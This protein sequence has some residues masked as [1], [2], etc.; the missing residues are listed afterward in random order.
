MD[1]AK[2]VEPL[3]QFRTV[4]RENKTM[5]DSCTAPRSIEYY[6]LKG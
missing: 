6:S 3:L 1:F 5:P 2:A 4:G